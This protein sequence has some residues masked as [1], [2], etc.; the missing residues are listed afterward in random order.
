[1]R[2][3]ALLLSL[4]LAPAALANGVLRWGFGAEDM[5][6]AGAFGGT[7]GDVIT[8]IQINPALLSALDGNQ[9][10]LS[11][12][13]LSGNSEFK[14]GGVTSGLTD[15][16]GGYPDLALSW[17]PKDSSL[18][19][20]F[21]VSP[22]SAL[23]A[24]W[25]YLDAPGGIGGISY[26]VL[27]HESRFVAVRLAL[28]AS[29]QINDQLSLGISAGAIH[30]EINVNAPFIFQTNPAL[31]NAKVDLDLETAGW[32][33]SVELGALYRPAN[34]WTFG[35]RM[36]LPVSLDNSGSANIDYS[37]QLPALGL[38]PSSALAEYKARTRTQLPLTIGAGSTWQASEKWSHGLWIDWHQ[39][40]K[41]YDTLRVNF[42]DG[43][44]ADI[45]NAIGS[46]P[47]DGVPLD[48]KDRFVF[49][50]GTACKI[51]DEW[52]LRGGYRYGESPV[53]DHLVTPLN[54][55]TLAH[56]LTLGASWQREGWVLDFAYGYEFENAS[57]IGVSGYN[58]GEYSNSS[59]KTFVHH[60][61]VSVGREF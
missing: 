32:A 44:N 2:Y 45:N 54:A 21:G 26:G 51:S 36:K 31:A 3:T 38:A 59:L 33:P 48:W 1:M 29:W 25:N 49:S 10:K 57:R 16:E 42:S 35:S 23:E 50:L 34:Q 5:G 61:G 15:G 37:A 6:A 28:A 56:A 47:S 41:S 17:R 8:A 52:T 13:Y 19:F 30:S 9:W 14:S 12:R 20:G 7:D 43:S 24:K 60:L 55:A 18:T 4:A 46:A 27:E 22:I 11:A 40:S 58:A 53:P 39:W